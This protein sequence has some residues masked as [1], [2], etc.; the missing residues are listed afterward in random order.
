MVTLC[1]PF[2]RL[3]LYVNFIIISSFFYVLFFT[4]RYNSLPVLSRDMLDR[5][6]ERFMFSKATFDS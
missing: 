2:K 6:H 5:I 4:G 3:I 1:R